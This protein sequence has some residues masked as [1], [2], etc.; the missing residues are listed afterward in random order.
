MM[1][2]K[3]ILLIDDSEVDNYIT[4]QLLLKN[5]VTE[6]IVVHSSAVDALSYLDG[7][8]NEHE[9]IPDY[10]FLDIRMPEMDGFEFLDEYKL[11]PDSIKN[12]CIIYMLSSSGDPNDVARARQYSYVKTFLRKPLD[13]IV[14]KE[15]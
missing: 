5:D 10:I 6:N 4:K 14:L 1:K 7:I 12:K 3:T 15:L 13:G 9:Q 2:A 8:S 11:L